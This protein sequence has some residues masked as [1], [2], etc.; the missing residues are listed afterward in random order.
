MGNIITATTC[1]LS[2][3]ASFEAVSAFNAP[4]STASASHTSLP[5]FARRIFIGRI[6]AIFPLIPKNGRSDIIVIQ[7]HDCISDKFWWRDNSQFISRNGSEE[8]K[9]V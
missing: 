6:P 7:T 4:S 5:R 8:Q 3:S 1:H 9:P 2:G